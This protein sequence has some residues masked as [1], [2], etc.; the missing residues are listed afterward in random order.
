ME[1]VTS[2]RLHGPPL[3][4][5]LEFSPHVSQ[6][7]LV[8][9]WRYVAALQN[10]DSNTYTL[11]QGRHTL[12]EQEDKLFHQGIPGLGFWGFKCTPS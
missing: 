2:N 8:S 3:V 6:S 7:N 5:P 4:L 11:Y 9:T 10:V 12:V 1:E